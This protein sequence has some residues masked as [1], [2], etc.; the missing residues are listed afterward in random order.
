MKQ[1]LIVVG[2]WAAL[3][4]STFAQQPSLEQLRQ[5]VAELEVRWNDYPTLRGAVG[6]DLRAARLAL[7]VRLQKDLGYF[8]EKAQSGDK[9]MQ[10]ELGRISQEIN[11]QN[12]KLINQTQQ[13]TDQGSDNSPQPRASPVAKPQ[14]QAAIPPTVGVNEQPKSQQAP[15]PAQKATKSPTEQNSTTAQQPTVSSVVIP[16]G[17]KYTVDITRDW[18]V[19][20]NSNCSNRPFGQEAAVWKVK[21]SLNG[22]NKDGTAI[23]STEGL[24]YVEAD[25]RTVDIFAFSQKDP[26]TNVTLLSGSTHAYVGHLAAHTRTVELIFDNKTLAEATDIVDLLDHHPEQIRAA[27]NSNTL[28]LRMFQ[29]TYSRAEA[30]DTGRLY[31]ALTQHTEAVDLVKSLDAAALSGSALTVSLTPDEMHAPAGSQEQLQLRVSAYDDGKH[32]LSQLLNNVQLDTGTLALAKS[33][34]KFI[35]DHGFKQAT[36]QSGAAA[37][38]TALATASSGTSHDLIVIDNPCY[39]F[40]VAPL[41]NGTSGLQPA[42]SFKFRYDYYSPG[43]ALVFRLRGEGEG[44]DSTKYFQRLKVSGEPT[45]FLVKD[46]GGWQI[47]G[48]GLGTYSFTR[49]NGNTVS[50]WRAGGKVEIKTP[51]LLMF[52]QLAGADSKPTFNLEASAA[53]GDATTTRTTDFDFRAR[54]LYTLRAST[55]VSLDFNAAAGASNTAR[56]GNSKNFSY[57]DFGG[58]YNFSSDWD[59]VVRYQ[60]GKQDPD[61]KKFCGWQTG[62]AFV[63][64][65]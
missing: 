29:I 64:G 58:R 41:A 51:I 10:A 39:Q 28:S 17:F 44:A 14:P 52:N 45:V 23:L 8:T 36:T 35:A 37:A 62:F 32:L 63:T 60:C 31:N 61:Y 65:R 26:T 33:D 5:S 27:L 18:G 43:N 46:K 20:A 19:N 11:Q 47:V 7:V 50:E 16:S 53:G 6:P 9:A 56:F 15:V 57:L 25:G 40:S 59:Y 34:L 49:P 30:L 21:V 4:A 12:M 2:I 13:P 38:N 1:L 3:T 54:F 48:G 22:L 42:A 55:K 24:L